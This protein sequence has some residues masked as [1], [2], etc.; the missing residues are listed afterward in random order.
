MSGKGCPI[1]ESIEDEG[2]CRGTVTELESGY[3]TTQR[4]QTLRGY[5]CLVFKRHAVELHDLHEDEAQAFVRDLRRV[6]RA[7]QEVT[8]AVKMN[9]EI[10]GNTIPHLHAHFYPRRPGD[11]FEDGP[12]DTRRLPVVLNEEEFGRFVSGLR[13][14]LEEA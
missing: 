14:A 12:V 10:H 13:A 1:C 7:A 3:L 4:E 5:C 6:G 9:V 2:V 8:G 11:R